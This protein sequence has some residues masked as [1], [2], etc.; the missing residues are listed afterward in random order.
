[1]LFDKAETS[2]PW[3]AR[4]PDYSD[5][6]QG[7]CDCPDCRAARD[8]P[9]SPYDEGE[10]FDEDDPFE[11]IGWG[12]PPGITVPK[13]MPPELAKLLLAGVIEG[14]V[15]NETPDQTLARMQREMRM[16]LPPAKRG[17]KGGKKKR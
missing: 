14:M 10:E 3:S 11:G 17:K 15:R 8:E 5:L 4:G 7:P 12:L 2:C 16:G 9:V 6:L 13:G 1:M